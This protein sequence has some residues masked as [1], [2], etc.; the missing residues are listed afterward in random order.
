MKVMMGVL[1]DIFCDN[2]W[3]PEVQGTFQAFLN[4]LPLLFPG[5]CLKLWDLTPFVQLYLQIALFL[6]VQSYCSLHIS[7]AEHPKGPPPGLGAPLFCGLLFVLSSRALHSLK[8]RWKEI[9]EIIYMSLVHCYEKI[10][11]YHSSG[12]R[13]L[14]Q[15]LIGHETFLRGNMGCLS[16]LVHTA[17]KTLSVNQTLLNNCILNSIVWNDTFTFSQPQIQCEIKH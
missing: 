4:C 6:L 11:H 16:H 13:Q 17:G 9:S 1:P 10:L 14:F 8:R 5:D 12:C 7:F 2:H 3:D 15:Q